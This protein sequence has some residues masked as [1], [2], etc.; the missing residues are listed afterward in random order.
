MTRMLPC[1]DECL[2]GMEAADSFGRT[3]ARWGLFA[4][5]LTLASVGSFCN[6]LLFLSLVPFFKYTG[7]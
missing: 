1:V 3:H 6:C 2:R 7:L 4:L 5:C